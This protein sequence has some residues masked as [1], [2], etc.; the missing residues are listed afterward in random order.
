MS[1]SSPLPKYRLGFLKSISIYLKDW[2]VLNGSGR[3]LRRRKI[4]S[5]KSKR[6][7]ILSLYVGR[8]GRFGVE[9]H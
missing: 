2:I 5:A 6:H 1:T 8:V 4:I 3:F 9:R 7:L